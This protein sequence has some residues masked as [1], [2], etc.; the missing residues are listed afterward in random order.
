MTTHLLKTVNPHFGAVL[1]GKKTAELRINDRGFSVGDILVLREWS[2]AGRY[3]G[4]E[5]NARVTSILEQHPGLVTG[6]VMLSFE[7]VTPP[8]AP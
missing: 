5:V 7:R 6:Y 4:R 3:S 2:E 1:S 8:E